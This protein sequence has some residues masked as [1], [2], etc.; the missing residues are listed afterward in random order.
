MLRNVLELHTVKLD[1]RLGKAYQ[2]IAGAVNLLGEIDNIQSWQELVRFLRPT[3]LLCVAADCHIQGI[4]IGRRHQGIDCYLVAASAQFDSCLGLAGRILEHN[5][6]STAGAACAVSASS[7]WFGTLFLFLGRLW[8]REGGLVEFVDAAKLLD[9]L[10]VI[11][12]AD[13]AITVVVAGIS[14]TLSDDQ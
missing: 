6:L 11:V 10:G 9:R 3:P 14:P 1:V 4:L 7:R 5:N 2:D 12:N 13:V 8:L